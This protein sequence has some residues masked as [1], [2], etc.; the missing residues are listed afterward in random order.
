MPPKPQW[1]ATL[2]DAGKKSFDNFCTK[3]KNYKRYFGKKGSSTPRSK[4][5]ERTD[6]E[7]LKHRKVIYKLPWVGTLD[8]A[9]K[10]SFTNFRAK[11]KQYQH[12][13]GK[14]GSATPRSQIYERTNDEWFEQRQVTKRENTIYTYFDHNMMT[15]F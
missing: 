5:C 8:D 12:R 11:R 3:R 14:K 7:W 1:Y 4:T 13:R 9:G 6:D 15:Q 2:D 10:Q